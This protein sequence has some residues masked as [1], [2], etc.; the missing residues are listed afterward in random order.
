M[1]GC[2]MGDFLPVRSCAMLCSVGQKYGK[3]VLESSRPHTTT[4]S[5]LQHVAQ[6][7]TALHHE[8]EAGP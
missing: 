7:D 4:A 6:H 1:I 8:R 2:D 5:T 3:T